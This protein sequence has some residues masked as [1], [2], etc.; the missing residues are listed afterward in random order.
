MEHLRWVSLIA[1]VAASSACSLGLGGTLLEGG[2][3]A[4]PPLDAAPARTLDSGSTVADASVTHDAANAIDASAPDAFVGVD[5]ASSD[6][7][8]TSVDCAGVLCDGLCLSDH[9][10]ATCTAGHALCAAT[11]TCGDCSDCIE[12]G[13]VA[14]PVACYAC[15]SMGQNPV[16]TCELDD[17]DGYCLDSVYPNGGTHCPCPDFDVATCPGDNQICVQVD[18]QEPVCVT[19]GETYYATDGALCQANAS[20]NATASPPHCD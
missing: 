13:G 19:C 4:G 6:G 8:T 1:A 2:D 15:D 5:A 3:D 17:A 12:S 16:G 7:A 20:C 18:N 11:N 10:C 9:T 14:H